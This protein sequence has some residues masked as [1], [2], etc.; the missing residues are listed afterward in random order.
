MVS[1]YSVTVRVSGTYRLVSIIRVLAGFQ[2]VAM[3]AG[4]N[5]VGVCNV[6]LNAGNDGVGIRTIMLGDGPSV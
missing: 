6:T 5:A 3:N 4:N 2:L 1:D